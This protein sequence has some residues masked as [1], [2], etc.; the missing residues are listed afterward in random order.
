MSTRIRAVCHVG[1]LAWAILAVGC[2]PQA[3]KAPV[4][5]PSAATTE[6]EADRANEGIVEIED[7]LRSALYQL[8]PENLNIDSR[9]DDA[10]AVLN[11]WWAA[12]EASKVIP[13]G[14]SSAAIPADRVPAELL[15]ALENEAFDG[16]DGRHIRA[17]YFAEHIAESLSAGADTDLDRVL[18]VFEW[19]CRNLALRSFDQP[20][21]P[22]TFYEAL[23]VGQMRPEDRA[24]VL[25]GILKQLHYDC[26]VLRPSAELVAG[27][28]WLFGVIVENQVYLF[29]LALGLPVPQGDRPV[30]E[31]FQQP[32]TLAQL[33]EHPEWLALLS[34]RADQPYPFTAEDLTHLHVDVITSPRSWTKRMWSIE[35]LLPGEMLCVLYD[36]PSAEA[37][38]PSLFDRVASAIP[39]IAANDVG[40]WSDPIRQ[41]ARMAAIDAP[42]V[43]AYQE[44][45]I[46]FIVPVEYQA[47]RETGTQRRVETQRQLRIRTEQLLGNRLEALSQYVTIRQLSFTQP[48]EPPLIPVYQRAADDAFFWSTVCKF[49]LG[50]TETAITQLQD[51]LKRY[52]RG[53]QWI[54]VA[55]SML[56]DAYQ[57][58]G[59]TEEL[60][61]IAAV[62]ESDDPY[63]DRHAL[64][65]RLAMPAAEK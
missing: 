62:Q 64:L 60:L 10:V 18:R 44:A 32:A 42:T 55:R 51:Y 50:E 26:V 23:I 12:A 21:L 58:S 39:G 36:P 56:V 35:Q 27:Q 1:W 31:Q 8:Q 61:K 9:L 19:G 30:A 46:P 14:T 7:Q 41:E 34:P 22:F 11:N 6:S 59:N 5:D 28:P 54:Y 4:A 47:D 16:T 38:R 13:E 33:K 2:Q 45:L 65:A 17:C 24:M 63:R 40:V 3:A 57:K 37:D 43:R 49:E 25:A 53:G 20:Q 48:P 52:R 15:S 29:D